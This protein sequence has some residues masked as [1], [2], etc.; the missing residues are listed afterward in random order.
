MI[1]ETILHYKILE[2]LGEG[3]MGTVYKAQDTKLDRFVALKFLSSNITVSEDD[4][5]RF[6]QEAK[7]ASAMNHPNVCTI[8]DIQE[9][10]SQLFIV[11]EFVDGKTL[12]DK[13]GSLSEKQILEIG[14]Q[15]AEGLSAAHEKGIVHRDIKPENIMLRK[16]GIAQIMDF[17]LAKLHS[18][19]EG[20]RL[21][22]VGTTMG[23]M[24]YMSP[25]QVQGLDV[26][27]RSD[28]F[29]FG[30]VLY[31]MFAGDSPF[32]GM[33][34]T[35]IMYEIVNVE[36]PPIS[37]VKEGIDPQLD[38]IILECLEKDKDDRYQSAKELAKNLRKIK[39][40]TGQR[41]SR[42]YNVNS[43]AFKTASKESQISKS[44][45][46]ISIE[47]F[48]KRFYLGNLLNLRNIS[49]L[50]IIFL[51][52]YILIQA[53][54][55][56]TEVSKSV[57]TFT[58]QLDQD[59]FFDLTYPA[60]NI[61]SDGSKIVYSA[62]SKL[63]LRNLSSLEAIEIP[64]TE[65]A[66]N[67]VFSPVGNSIV[68]FQLGKLKKLA[69]NGGAA[70]VLVTTDDVSR[71][72]SWGKGGYIAYAPSTNTGISIIPE[73]G[74]TPKQV[75]FVDSL[76]NERTHRWPQFLPDGKHI[77]FTVG[78][79]DNP[80]YYEDANIDVVNIETGE[81]KNIIKGASTAKY[82]KTGQIIYSK[83]GTLYSVPFDLDELEVKGPPV[84]V[85]DGVNGDLTSGTMH[86]S[87]S[88]NGTLTYIPGDVEGGNRT[89][90]LINENGE[91]TID[92]PPDNYIEPR[93]SPDGK[94]IAL[95]IRKNTGFDIWIYNMERKTLRKFTFGGQN[96]TP[97]WSSDSKRIAFM[98]V[99]PSNE[100]GIF[101]KNADGS[102]K[103]EEV[104]HSNSR[105]YLDG[106]SRD[107][108]ILL[109]QLLGGSGNQT[110]IYYLKL[111]GEKRLYP[112][113]STRNDEYTSSFSPD[114]KW[115]AYLSSETGSY[116]V[117]VQS[118]PDKNG[119]QQVSTKGS[120][121]VV[122]APDGKTI[123]YESN[124]IIYG[125]PITLSNNIIAGKP[126]EIIR[127]L[128]LLSVDSGHTFDVSSDSKYILTTKPAK[129]SVNQKLVV[130]VNWFEEIEN[131]VS[132]ENS[133]N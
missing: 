121:T 73:N 101:I 22:K 128:S 109:V 99:L 5:A 31:E 65:N 74:G 81:R 37:T 57:I 29:S 126:K 27:H 63:F 19:A 8:Y 46:S 120:S 100:V 68:F 102:D 93:M 34:E 87:I 107:G 122:W 125:I 123:Y 117:Y 38:E 77:L 51:L 112:Y 18:S 64:G 21:T 13:K 104:Y 25:E 20:S 96:R 1:G 114:G 14:I 43:A 26:D 61:T 80:D 133:L 2:K 106:W 36:A 40:S 82:I 88:D 103:E 116:Q 42:V 30:V 50:I 130:V 32:K 17:G 83:S 105:T 90:Y 7:T 79:L 12:K 35:A 60:V 33:H 3:G 24:G 28:I 85:V 92:I 45:G 86:Y 41:K 10:D 6:I 62:N 66:L 56:K 78:Y 55:N 15:V 111:N 54:R 23:T 89:L 69:L 72:V 127:G 67:P 113:L 110:D 129:G 9:N 95:V 39:K 119:K 108:S 118:F 44:S 124:S 53:P 98:R 97:V 16:D 49:W 75:S 70:T 71:G 47:A 76:R 4:K 52:G 59:Y 58:S 84:P 91:K 132:Q 11:M 115:V 131:R 94:E 48:N